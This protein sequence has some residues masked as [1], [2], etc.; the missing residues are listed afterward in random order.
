M[1]Q[2][3]SVLLK[4]A[5][6][7]G[8]KVAPESGLAM[9][10]GGLKRFSMDIFSGGGDEEAQAQAAVKVADIE[11]ARQVKIV[12]IERLQMEIEQDSIEMKKNRLAA[13]RQ[14]IRNDDQT[15]SSLI[16]SIQQIPEEAPPS[17]PKKTLHDV[18]SLLDSDLKS[19]EHCKR[20]LTRLEQD[21]VEKLPLLESEDGEPSLTE[22]EMAVYASLK[23][24]LS[25]AAEYFEGELKAET[26]K[27]IE[28]VSAVYVKLSHRQNLSL[29]RKSL[30]ELEGTLKT[31][32]SGDEKDAQKA[33]ISNRESALDDLATVNFGEEPKPWYA[34]DIDI[35]MPQIP[36]MPK[37]PD[38]PKPF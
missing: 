15:R 38:I 30:T 25:I 17:L 7:R 6:R 28:D 9:L 31:M 14:D 18:R 36:A 22:E 13:L 32:E 35:K 27:Q 2:R 23:A 33:L 5:P 16:E 34:V 29:K 26:M 1:E 37:M 20:V 10:K 8:V 21:L 12:E 24:E 19:E 4:T 11:K 3:I